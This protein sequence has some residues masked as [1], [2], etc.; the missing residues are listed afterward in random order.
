M[1]FIIIKKKLKIFNWTKK[2]RELLKKY[3]SRSIL[4]KIFLTNYCNEKSYNCFFKCKI[5]L[6][7]NYTANK[8]NYKRLI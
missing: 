5:L 1:W 2:F 8:N 3:K 4:K 6:F 7:N